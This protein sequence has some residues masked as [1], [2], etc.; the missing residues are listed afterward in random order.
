[1]YRKLKFII[2]LMIFVIL[3][4][5]YLGWIRETFPNPT[6][7]FLIRFTSGGI[8]GAILVLYYF[9]KFLQEVAIDKNLPPDIAIV[10]IKPDK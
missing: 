8:V 9:R 3:S 5:Y 2:A 1:M 4:W 10:R 7:A 6:T